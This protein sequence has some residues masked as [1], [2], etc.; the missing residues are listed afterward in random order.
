MIAFRTLLATFV[1]SIAAASAAADPSVLPRDGQKVHRCVGLH[2]EIVFSGDACAATEAAAGGVS[3]SAAS[4]PIPAADSCP[5]TAAELRERVVA[6]IARHDP[7]A[8]AGL[9]R[10]RGVGSGAARSRLRALRDLAKHELLAIDSS[11]DA[12]SADSEGAA[13]PTD[14]LRV[15]TG[16][17]DTGGVHEQSFGIEAEGGCYWLVW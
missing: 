5:A 15:R 3:G 11:D 10:W 9:L 17:G 1:L 8:I 6:A 13:A 12:A 2:G 16:G 14:G 7:N 4:S